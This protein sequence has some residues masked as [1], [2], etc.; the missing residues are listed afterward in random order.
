[1]NRI[2]KYIKKDPEKGLIFTK[3]PVCEVEV[4][5][6][7]DWAKSPIDRK[8]TLGYCLYVWG[9]LVTWRSKK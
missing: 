1:M 6:N 8:S 2:L 3:S 5:T 4:Y 9:N 7:A